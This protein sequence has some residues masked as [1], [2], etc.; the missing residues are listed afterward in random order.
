MEDLDIIIFTSILIVLFILFAIG[1]YI[2]FVRME[3][4][5]FDSN[6]EKGGVDTFIRFLSKIFN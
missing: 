4:S 2:Q 3:N 6:K 1:T 5:R